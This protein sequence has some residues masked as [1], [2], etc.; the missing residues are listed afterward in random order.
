MHKHVGKKLEG[1]EPGTLD[2]IERKPFV[3]S[4]KHKIGRQKNTNIDQQ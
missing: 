1:L 4:W 3:E 2:I